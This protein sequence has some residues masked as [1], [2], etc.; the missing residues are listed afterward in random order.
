MTDHFYYNCLV[1]DA[2]IPQGGANIEDVPPPRP[3]RPQRPYETKPNAYTPPPRTDI[4]ERRQF[5]PQ[6]GPEVPPRNFGINSSVHQRTCS[7]PVDMGAGD[8]EWSPS[9]YQNN[10][11]VPFTEP[12]SKSEDSQ[13]RSPAWLQDARGQ[14]ECSIEPP[15]R[16][17]GWHYSM[18]QLMNEYNYPRDQS[19]ALSPRWQNDSRT[20]FSNNS[21]SN[22]GSSEPS[23]VVPQRLARSHPG[24]AEP[25]PGLPQRSPR[26]NPGSAEPSPRPPQKSQRRNTIDNSPSYDYPLTSPRKHEFHQVSS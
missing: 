12:D 11:H 4:E 18:N 2:V 20:N 19:N 26:S 1:P 17:P 24:S 5:F 14:V 6:H 10:S 3:P 21:S 8:Y 9:W 13:V 16:S 25:S 15:S 7:E 23:P 22:P